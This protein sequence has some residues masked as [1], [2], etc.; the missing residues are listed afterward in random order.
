MSKREIQAVEPL[1]PHRG[2]MSLLDGMIVV[3]L[4]KAV[5]QVEI[6]PDN[7]FITANGVPA[8]VGIEYM[9]QTI[10]AYSGKINQGKGL[11][12]QVGFLLGSRSY[13]SE[14]D[15]FLLGE[16]L[17]IEVIPFYMDEGQL[18]VFD[19]IIK[20]ND[21][22]CVNAKLNVFQPNNIEEILKHEENE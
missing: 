7:L 4:E 13:K 6:R 12:P 19:C 15:Y 20:I 8:L 11:L 2:K 22:I 9:A 10:A 17:T 18:S 14:V 5:S 1:I 16:V 3:N 21:K